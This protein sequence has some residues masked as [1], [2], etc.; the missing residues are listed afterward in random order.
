MFGLGVDTCSRTAPNTSWCQSVCM[1]ACLLHSCLAE[2]KTQLLA[3]IDFSDREDFPVQG[4][5]P[6]NR[7][8]SLL[9]GNGAPSPWSNGTFQPVCWRAGWEKGL[10]VQ[11]K[12]GWQHQHGSL[13]RWKN[14]IAQGISKPYGT[15]S[16]PR[17]SL[18]LAYRSA[19]LVW[20]SCCKRK[21]RFFL[22]TSP[23]VWFCKRHL[24]C[25]SEFSLLCTL[26]GSR[27]ALRKMFSI[28]QERWTNR[29]LR[30]YVEKT[31]F[32]K[33]LSMTK[34]NWMLIFLI[35]LH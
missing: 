10:R 26:S 4:H 18:E 23:E 13:L 11:A 3:L 2:P 35:N 16:C 29:T 33:S 8:R 34:N 6:S 28:S 24:F 22:K 32:Q 27:H 20:K 15:G 21:A 1:C 19:S 30:H 25:T 17:L 14:L 9:A 31:A 5:T 12:G 7:L